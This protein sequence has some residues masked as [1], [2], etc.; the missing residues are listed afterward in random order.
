MYSTIL[1]PVDGSGG[2]DGAVSRTFE[3]ARRFGAA[4][5]VLHVVDAEPGPA[6]LDRTQRERVRRPLEKRGRQATARI[7]DRA[8]ELGVDATRTVR[9]GTPSRT[10][11][12]YADEHDVDLI[13]MGTHG[14]TGPERVRLGSTTERVITRTDSPVL[15]VPVADGDGTDVDSIEYDRV[16]IA[17]D[18]SDAAERA[19]E[20]GLETAEAYDSAVYVAYVVDATTYELADAPRSIVGLLKDGGRNAVESIATEG[21]DRGLSVGIDV[22]RGVPH[23]EIVEYADGVGGDLVVMGTRGRGGAA[24]GFLGSTT[25]RVLRRTPHPILTVG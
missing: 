9:D 13:V 10:I 6:G 19:A 15:A 3:F 23:D 4:V 8:A 20:R 22:L 2:D 16:V 1:V 17:T 25:A 24:G 12:E 14:R 18:G 11:L 7:A 21:R 5:H